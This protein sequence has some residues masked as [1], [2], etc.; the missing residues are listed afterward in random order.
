MA[1]APTGN[2]LG[3]INTL[4]ELAIPYEYVYAREFSEGLAPAKNAKGKWENRIY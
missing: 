1:Y 4:G 2:R 3:F